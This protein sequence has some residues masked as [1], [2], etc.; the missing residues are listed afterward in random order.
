MFNDPENFRL[1][2]F[3]RKCQSKYISYE[4]A[5][6]DLSVETLVFPPCIV[7]YLGNFWFLELLLCTTFVRVILKYNLV[8][9]YPI[10]PGPHFNVLCAGF[11]NLIVNSTYAFLYYQS[12]HTLNVKKYYNIESTTLTWYWYTFLTYWSMQC[13]LHISLSSCGFFSVLQ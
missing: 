5:S 11:F 6:G 10:C 4:K 9:F 12:L 8:K 13:A 3:R 2:I 7:L 1:T